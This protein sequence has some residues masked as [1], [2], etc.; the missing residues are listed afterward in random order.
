MDVEG[1]ARI[2]GKIWIQDEERTLKFKILVNAHCVIGGHCGHNATESQVRA[3]FLWTNLEADGAE[4]VQLCI[5]CIVSRT[6]DRI[7]RP[8][9]AALHGQRPNELVHLDS[10]YMGQSDTRNLTY[11]LL[12]KD[13]LTGYTWLQVSELADSEAAPSHCQNGYQRLVV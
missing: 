3:S 6:G 9:S 10:L 1:I 2:A 5:H 7:P 12:M 13:Y 11:L 4:F 8:L